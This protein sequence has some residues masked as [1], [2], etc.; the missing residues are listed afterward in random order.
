MRTRKIHEG[1]DGAIT[2]LVGALL[3]NKTTSGNCNSVTSP[4]KDSG[5]VS[6]QP[7]STALSSRYRLRTQTRRESLVHHSVG[8]DPLPR[9]LD[10]VCD[11]LLAA[12]REGPSLISYAAWLL[13]SEAPFVTRTGQDSCRRV[14]FFWLLHVTGLTGLLW[15]F[16]P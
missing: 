1:N 12:G 13:H 16:G 14:I 7:K 6:R 4:S 3:L 2:R 10:A 5:V 11:Q 8:H 15:R 9:Q